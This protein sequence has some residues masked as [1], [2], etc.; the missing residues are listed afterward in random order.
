MYTFNDSWKDKVSNLVNLFEAL[1]FLDTHSN[2]M[3]DQTIT[4][5]EVSN[6]VKA[7]KYNKSAGSDGIAGELIKY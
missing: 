1:S 5:A 3:L 2:G 7:I 4:L 6:V